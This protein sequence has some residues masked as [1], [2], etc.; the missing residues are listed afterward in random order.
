M[1]FLLIVHPTHRGRICSTACNEAVILRAI[2]LEPTSPA[3]P[4]LS[5]DAAPAR[6]FGP[7]HVHL[8]CSIGNARDVVTSVT[9]LN[10]TMKSAAVEAS[11]AS[12]ITIASGLPRS[13]RNSWTITLFGILGCLKR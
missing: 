13:P 11:G 12:K 1:L 6:G 3:S 2:R 8:N 10:W 4:V 5:P 7:H 9:R